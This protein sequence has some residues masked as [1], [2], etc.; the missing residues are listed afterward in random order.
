MTYLRRRLAWRLFG[1]VVLTAGLWFSWEAVMYG[2]AMQ[3]HDFTVYISEEYM[4]AQRRLNRTWPH[5][6]R[7]LPEYIKSQKDYSRDKRLRSILKYYSE[8]CRSFTMLTVTHTACTYKLQLNG[9]SPT[10]RSTV[11]PD[12]GACSY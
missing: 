6:L 1:T 12:D 9:W 7:K 11:N 8:N 5:N 10:C 3:V 4:P 2:R